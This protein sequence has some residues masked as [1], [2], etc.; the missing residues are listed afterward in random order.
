VAGSLWRCPHLLFL[1]SMGP[2]MFLNVFYWT[3]GAAPEFPLRDGLKFIELPP[4]FL[5]FNFSAHTSTKLFPRTGRDS[6]APTPCCSR[7]NPTIRSFRSHCPR[8]FTVDFCPTICPFISEAVRDA[9]SFCPLVSPLFQQS[10][11]DLAFFLKAGS[12]LSPQ[13]ALFAGAF[14]VFFY[15]VPSRFHFRCFFWNRTLSPSFFFFV[16]RPLA[17]FS[18]SFCAFRVWGTSSPCC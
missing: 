8:P 5:C 11:V 13:K 10:F 3:A 15:S 4:T 16:G 6:N 14:P 17:L 18:R 1:V 2:R 9:L 7:F 12:F